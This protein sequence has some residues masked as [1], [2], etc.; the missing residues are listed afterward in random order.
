MSDFEDLKSGVTTDVALDAF[1]AG[2]NKGPDR[3]FI[4]DSWFAPRETRLRAFLPEPLTEEAAEALRDAV[5]QKRHI[6][7]VIDWLQHGALPWPDYDAW[8]A[9]ENRR[10]AVERMRTG[11]F[12]W[13]DVE[14]CRSRVR[15]PGTR[16]VAR[17]GACPECETPGRDLTWIHFSSPAWTWTL[18]CGREGWLTVCDGCHLQISFFMESMN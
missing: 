4:T 11:Y 2:C 1:C 3:L 17:A 16:P 5:L 10:L 14:A 7:T 8:R 15:D 9:E 18:R 13:E 12:P 6:D